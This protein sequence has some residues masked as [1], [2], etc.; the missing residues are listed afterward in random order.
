LLLLLI[1]CGIGPDRTGPIPV[2]F[3]VAVAIAVVVIIVIITRFLNALLL[4]N[5]LLF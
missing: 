4:T 3:A 2:T 5:W 1:F